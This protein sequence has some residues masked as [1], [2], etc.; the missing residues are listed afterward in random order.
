MSFCRQLMVVVMMA[1]SGSGSESKS[2]EGEEKS[3][4]HAVKEVKK[5]KD[6]SHVKWV[7]QIQAP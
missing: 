3:E 1:P 5:R 4:S 6:G 7:I 2:E